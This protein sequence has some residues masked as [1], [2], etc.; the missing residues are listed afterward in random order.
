MRNN[1]LIIIVGLIVIGFAFMA[2]RSDDS[3]DI[4]AERKDTMVEDNVMEDDEI[5]E[6]NMS[7]KQSGIYGLYSPEKV[8]NA[9]G[10]VVL[11]FHATWCPTCK[12]LNNAIESH[13]SEI[14]SDVTI[15][16]VDYDSNIA[17][18]QKYGVTVQHTLVQVDN[19]GEMIAKWTGSP[20][21]SD[22]V[23]KIN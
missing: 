20:S 3:K 9:E 7:D 12:A 23:S 10:K 13:I 14:P 21:L 8:T 15:L 5:V 1:I 4:T 6:E 19:N 16:K 11:F 18:R 2:F 17:L 22:L